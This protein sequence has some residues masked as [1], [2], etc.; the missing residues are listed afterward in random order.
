MS[1]YRVIGSE[2]RRYGSRVT[3]TTGGKTAVRRAFIQ[4]LRYRNRVYIGGDCRD[5]GDVRREKY[6]FVG[7]ADCELTEGRTVIESA[8]G[9]YIVKRRETYLVGDEPVYVWA[10]LVP[11][12]EAWEDDYDADTAAD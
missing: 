8:G 3:V 4:P 6:L 11:F 10:I 7:T 5:I 1:V 2:I 12:G 9:K